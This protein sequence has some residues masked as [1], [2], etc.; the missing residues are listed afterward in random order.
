MSAFSPSI[1]SYFDSIV[2]SLHKVFIGQVYRDQ[3]ASLHD[4]KAYIWSSQIRLAE[5]GT[6]S[7][8]K[9]IV[10]NLQVLDKNV[11]LIR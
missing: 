8:N 5:G 2:H 1:P 10:Y 11:Y 4:K 7:R 3:N 6:S 9:F